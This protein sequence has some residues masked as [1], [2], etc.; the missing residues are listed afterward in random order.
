MN[1][2]HGRV[3]VVNEGALQVRS[4]RDHLGHHLGV[5]FGMHQDLESRRSTEGLDEG[6][7]R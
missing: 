5:T 1:R 3:R 2:K 4:L 7:G 6:P